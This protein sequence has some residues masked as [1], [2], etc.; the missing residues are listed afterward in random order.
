MF[1]FFS[2][3]WGAVQMF[4]NVIANIFLSLRTAVMILVSSSTFLGTA[5]MYM[6][7]VVSSSV[8]IVFAIAVVKF[9]VGR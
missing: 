8:L 5:A 2:N 9:V 1:S 3:I 6:P 4:L 7:I